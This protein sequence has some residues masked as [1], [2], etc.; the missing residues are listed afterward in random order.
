MIQAALGKVAKIL[1]VPANVL[2]LASH[3]QPIRFYSVSDDVSI[4]EARKF[5]AYIFYHEE[6]QHKR[7]QMGWLPVVCCFRGITD[8]Q[9]R[10]RL[11]NVEATANYPGPWGFYASNPTSGRQCLYSVRCDNSLRMESALSRAIT[12]LLTD[13]I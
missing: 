8:S 10:R 7:G 13:T 1:G 6:E 3:K 4:A 2:L 5:V 12:G 11:G 9:I